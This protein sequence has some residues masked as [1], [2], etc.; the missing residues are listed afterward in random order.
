ML[1][2]SNHITHVT[3]DELNVIID[4]QHVNLFNVIVIFNISNYIIASNNISGT[5]IQLSS[6]AKSELKFTLAITEKKITAI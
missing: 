1:Q 3:L 5:N 4:F 2:F 6:L